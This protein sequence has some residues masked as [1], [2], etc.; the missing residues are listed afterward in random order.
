MKHNAETEA[1][2]LLMEIENLDMLLDHVDQT[3]YA[4]VCLYLSRFL[5]L[6]NYIK[7][8]LNNLFL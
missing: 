7:L 5:I 3:T 2:D 1:C 4:R 6:L 8:E